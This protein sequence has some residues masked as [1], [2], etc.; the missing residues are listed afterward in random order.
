MTFPWDSGLKKNEEKVLPTMEK[1]GLELSAFG[2]QT[3]RGLRT[4]KTGGQKL[5]ILRRE[6]V[7]C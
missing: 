6:V 7:L 3:Q 5:I 2:G 4:D 1:K